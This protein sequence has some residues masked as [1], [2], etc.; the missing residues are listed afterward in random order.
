MPLAMAAPVALPNENAPGMLNIGP[1]AQ[2]EA[3]D[4]SHNPI[5]SVENLCPENEQADECG[6]GQPL[7]HHEMNNGE[8]P[9][10]KQH[11]DVES[12]LRREP[13]LPRQSKGRLLS[14]AL[15][16]GLPLLGSGGQ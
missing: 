8:N 10:R 9:V 14:G 5:N 15:I 16:D 2:D 3:L 7:G 12:D 4:I 1:R 6:G 13:L 11:G